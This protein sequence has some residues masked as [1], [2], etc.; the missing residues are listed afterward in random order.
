MRG[1]RRHPDWR[2]RLAAALRR[3]DRAAFC[4]ERCHCGHLANA[5]L[6]AV[7]D[8]DL[9]AMIAPQDRSRA[10]IEA[11]LA[12]LGVADHEELLDASFEAQPVSGA[13]D[14]DLGMVET[15]E[16][17]AL[18]VFSGGRFFCLRPSGLASRPMSLA[19]RAWR[20]G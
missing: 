11:G 7:T 19:H 9:I 4:D 12:V 17:P 13:R 5:A 2:T 1:L 6:Q 14:G 8:V 16:G 3:F 20:V 18:G 15:S 10:G